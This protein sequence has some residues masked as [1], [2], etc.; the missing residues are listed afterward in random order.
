MKDG[1]EL[2]YELQQHEDNTSEIKIRI[3]EIP[4]TIDDLESERNGKAQIVNDSKS[5]LDESVKKRE[6]LEKDILLIK[7][8]ISK[9]R[10]QLNKSTTNKEYQGFI[11]E[12]KFEEDKIL[13][14]EEKIIE[15]MLVSDEVME[16]IRESE[17]EYKS[18]S[19]DY[20]KKI[21]DLNENLKYYKNKLLEEE[22]NKKELRKPIPDN[23][24]NIYDN[25]I[26]KKNGK[27]ISNVETNF[28]GICNV[29]IRPQ[30]LSEL[31]TTNSIFICENCGRILY[32]KVKEDSDS[33]QK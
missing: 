21:E 17:T 1:L 5:K 29:M 26:N 12:I 8:K 9:Y 2:L 33:N 15:E 22:N 25:L 24:I 30:R 19:N 23:L 13:T 11:S 27:A 16:E 31:I 10:E 14:V 3:D 32:K 7:E 4:K 28:C 6:K 20:N 18:I